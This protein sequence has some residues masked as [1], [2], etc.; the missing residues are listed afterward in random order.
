MAG[1]IYLRRV[2]GGQHCIIVSPYTAGDFLK[3]WG[4]FPIRQVAARVTKL[5]MRGAFETPIMGK[6]RLIDWLSRV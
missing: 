6:G 2:A 4:G 3:V 1:R 5:V